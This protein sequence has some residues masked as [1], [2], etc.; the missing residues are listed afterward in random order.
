MCRRPSKLTSPMTICSLLVLWTIFAG[1]GCQQLVTR[2]GYCLELGQRCFSC[3]DGIRGTTF[4]VPRLFISPLAGAGALCCIW[5][6]GSW[7]NR[8]VP[9]WTQSGHCRPPSFWVGIWAKLRTYVAANSQ[10]PRHDGSLGEEFVLP[11]YLAISSLKLHTSDFSVGE[12]TRRSPKVG[13]PTVPIYLVS[14]PWPTRWRDRVTQKLQR[15]ARSLYSLFD[16][17]LNLRSCYF[18][19]YED[20]ELLC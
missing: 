20:D 2:V 10:S 8:P 16:L 1:N 15:F 5:P 11:T 19:A 9:L 6:G 14:T 12:D 18:E 4:S 17:D 3:L 7:A 13:V